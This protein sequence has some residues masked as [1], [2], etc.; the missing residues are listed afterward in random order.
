MLK[1]LLLKP[2]T[3]WTIIHL[4]DGKQSKS[5]GCRWIFNTKFNVNGTIDKHKAR[6]NKLWFH[7]FSS[8]LIIHGFHHQFTADYSLFS[9]G[10]NS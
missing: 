4:P 10:S 5:I 1:Y 8:T 3:S 7:K 2:I 9:E 6:L